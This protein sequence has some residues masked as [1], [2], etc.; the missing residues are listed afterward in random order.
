V[1]EVMV[2]EER[3]REVS[4]D[5]ELCTQMEEDAG[6]LA[7]ETACRSKDKVGGNQEI[8][9][10]GGVDFASDSGVVAGRAFVF[11]DGPSIGGEPDETEGGSV[12]MRG[13]GAKVVERQVVFVE[14]KD[15]SQVKSG[16]RVSRTATMVLV[17][18][19]AAET[20]S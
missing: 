5:M 3:E 4:V 12:E 16:V 9:D 10:V 19:A 14:I 6:R 1:E 17:C 20:R 13:G 8:G 2:R 15:L 7:G 18:R 11:E